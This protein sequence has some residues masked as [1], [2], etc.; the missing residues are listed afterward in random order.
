MNKTKLGRFTTLVG[1]LFLISQTI[2]L[3]LSLISIL[4]QGVYSSWFFTLAREEPIYYVQYLV[5][6]PATS[7]MLVP[8]IKIGIQFRKK[9]TKGLRSAA[10]WLL[11]L[12]LARAV[13]YVLEAYLMS[14][15][16]AQ[17]FLK[18]YM[19]FFRVCTVLSFLVIAIMMVVYIAR[20]DD[21]ERTFSLVLFAVVVLMLI[22]AA[23]QCVHELF[24]RDF[25]AN[26]QVALVAFVLLDA[27]LEIAAYMLFGNYAVKPRK[28]YAQE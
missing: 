7:L 14:L 13:C 8:Y 6:V 9:E 15:N 4:G 1:W 27:A 11:T 3:I 18:N 24:V 2:Q 26:G 16:H 25:T 28:F 12:N 23:G 20:P 17:N 10:V 22:S 19:D 5:D 21:Y